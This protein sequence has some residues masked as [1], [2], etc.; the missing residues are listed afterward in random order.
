MAIKLSVFSALRSP[1]PSQ[2][3]QQHT[4]W[5]SD[6]VSETGGEERTQSIR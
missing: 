4:K 5:T 6:V 1:K 3:Y 2:C